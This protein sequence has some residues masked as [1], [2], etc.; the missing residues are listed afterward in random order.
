MWLRDKYNWGTAPVIAFIG[1][2]VPH[3]G[4]DL[5]IEAMPHIW[6]SYPDVCLL[7]AGGKTT[8]SANIKRWVAA[9]T[10]QQQSQV[11]LIDDF[12]EEEKPALFAACDMLV[13]PS[14]HESFGITFLEA[15]AARKPVIGSRIGAIPTVVQEDVDGLLIEHRSVD[16]L[17]Q[18]IRSLIEK[19][20][21][22]AQLGEN[23]YEKTVKNYT[24]DI[25]AAKF[26]SVYEAQIKK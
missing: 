19:P 23:G 11:A 17:V 15:W 13:F 1:Q 16:D 24:W 2:Q 20:K 18:A 21:W 12:S 4:I 14:G 8:Y 26:R 22:A 9:L 10:P 3:K 25:V 7:I 6:Q 5:L